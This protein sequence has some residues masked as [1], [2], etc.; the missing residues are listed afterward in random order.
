MKFTTI[1]SPRFYSQSVVD[2]VSKSPS[3]NPKP[4]LANYMK[5]QI[6]EDDINE[7]LLVSYNM[8]EER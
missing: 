2:R 3:V 4:R 7:W 1:M 6:R 5:G 8:K